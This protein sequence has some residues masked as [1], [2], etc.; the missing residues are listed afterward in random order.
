[1]VNFHGGG[2]V[3]GTLTAAD[4]LC[5]QV[6]ERAYATVVSVG[7]RLAPEYPAP[8]PYLDS[9]TATRWLVEHAVWSAA[10]RTGS[11]CSARAPGATWPR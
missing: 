4:W 10:I 7:Y 6:A 5:G 8:T 11:P 3:L 1:M 2:F 9:W